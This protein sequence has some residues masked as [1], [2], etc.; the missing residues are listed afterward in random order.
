MVSHSL[1]PGAVNTEI[2]AKGDSFYKI[3]GWLSRPINL[4][5][6][7]GAR[8]TLY[9]ALSEVCFLLLCCVMLSGIRWCTRAPLCSGVC[10]H[11][12]MRRRP[13]R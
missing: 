2:Y 11:A 9:A 3:I 1:H 8:T 4:T 10:A 12:C 13:A 5:E 7:E 6:E